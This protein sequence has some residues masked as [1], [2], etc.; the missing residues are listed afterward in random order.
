MRRLLLLPI[1]ACLA[2]FAPVAP[3]G[4]D[5]AFY[6]PSEL[7]TSCRVT[8]PSA[9]VGERVVLRVVVSANT[10]RPVTGDVEITVARSGEAARA[11]RAT[12]RA[13][14]TKTVRYE[15][16]PLRVVGPRLSRGDHIAS[17]RFTPDDDVV[18][19]QILTGCADRVRFR[20]GAQGEVGG[21]DTPLPDTGG[22]HLLALLFG[23]GLVATGGG[24]VG[25][26]RRSRS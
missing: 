3:A 12:L 16:A 13:T 26:S 23:A 19:D 18:N 24:L 15:D 20:V 4:A 22:P 14:W 11:A 21:Q 5:D 10:S 6:P 25:G 7:P 2:L 8:V 1:V 17:I 9:V